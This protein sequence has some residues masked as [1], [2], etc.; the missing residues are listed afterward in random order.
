[1]CA[2]H[3]HDRQTLASFNNR[4]TRMIRR[5]CSE[6][7]T[8]PPNN[9]VKQRCCSSYVRIAKR[10][11]RLA[12]KPFKLSCAKRTAAMSKMLEE[13]LRQSNKNLHGDWEL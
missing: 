5:T 4:A 9:G 2:N 13:M 7:R 3:K 1:M 10:K 8:S 6:A 11:D 12:L